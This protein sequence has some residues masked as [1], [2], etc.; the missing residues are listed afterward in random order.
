MASSIEVQMSFKGFIFRGFPARGL[1]RS[2][3]LE[4]TELIAPAQAAMLR[5]LESRDSFYFY[6]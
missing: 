2:S 1:L 3:K 4:R 5:R 6:Y